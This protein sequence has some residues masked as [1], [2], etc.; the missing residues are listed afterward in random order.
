MIT[1]KEIL[2]GS[3]EELT[4]Y[5]DM[6][7]IQPANKLLPGLHSN[8]LISKEGVTKQLSEIKSIGTISVVVTNDSK[9]LTLE[10]LFVKI[11]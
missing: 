8:L 11:I 1:K 3:I 10:S 9:N 7:Y 5:I 6:N 4:K 2:I